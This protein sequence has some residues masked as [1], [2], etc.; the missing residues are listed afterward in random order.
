MPIVDVYS[1]GFSW[2]VQIKPPKPPACV[3]EEVGSGNTVISNLSRVMHALLR[4]LL[5]AA[6]E[7][8]LTMR[9]AHFT[10]QNLAAAACALLPFQ[11]IC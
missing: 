9:W 4:A 3:A 8:R 5:R 10:A 2:E 1:R 7:R 11:V 6:P